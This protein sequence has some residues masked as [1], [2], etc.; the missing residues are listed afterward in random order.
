MEFRDANKAE[1]AEEAYLF[2]EEDAKP[3]A[4]RVLVDLVESHGGHEY[5]PAVAAA[6]APPAAVAA[7]NAPPAAA[8]VNRKTRRHRRQRKQRS[9]KRSARKHR[10][11]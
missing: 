4:L 11:N 3:A 9:L 6:N 8:V 7:A 2:A 5:A 10:R 1:G